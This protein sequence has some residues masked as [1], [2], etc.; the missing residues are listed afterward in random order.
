MAKKAA[1]KKSP[2]AVKYTEPALRERLKKKITAGDKGGRAGE[3]SAR[4]AQLLA[5]EYKK[6]GGGYVGPRKASQ[7]H[8]KKWT[9]E[10]WHTSDKK[11]AIRGKATTRYLPDKA[12]TD[13]TP[14]QKRATNAKKESASKQGKQFVANTLAAKKAG[15]RARRKS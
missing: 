1:A 8:L 12:W 4:K 7:E 2:A 6:A 14:A 13:L 5:A 15:K 10:K 9:E 3:W 11:P